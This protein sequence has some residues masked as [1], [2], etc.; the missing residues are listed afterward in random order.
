[1]TKDGSNSP[2]RR[3]RKPG[4]IRRL[5]LVPRDDDVVTSSTQWTQDDDTVEPGPPLGTRAPRSQSIC[6]AL[7]CTTSVS[8]RRRAGRSRS[9]CTRSPG[10]ASPSPSKVYGEDGWARDVRE[11]SSK[12]GHHSRDE[13]LAAFLP[14][15]AGL[16]KDEADEL[17]TRILGEWRRE[18]RGR[19]GAAHARWLTRATFSVMG[20]LIALV[21]L[22][23]LG[24]RAP[25]LG[26]D[27]AK[28][29]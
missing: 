24:V 17:S 22:A 9:S 6:C 15:F 16:P 2:D 3:R 23:L 11:S 26:T 1:M 12:Y 28:S 29:T 8:F 25:R 20:A 5:P 27:L 13:S 19:G 4:A 21:L 7:S 14:S 18:W 10:S